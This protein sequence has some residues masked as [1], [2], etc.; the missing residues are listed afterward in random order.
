MPTLSELVTPF[1]E[2]YIATTR[3]GE[4]YRYWLNHWTRALGDLDAAALTADHIRT[5]RRDQLPRLKPSTINDITSALYRLFAYHGIPLPQRLRPLRAN[6]ARTRFLTPQDEE[7]LREQLSAGQWL[8]VALAIHSGLRRSE[9]FC[10][11]RNDIRDGFLHVRDSKNGSARFVPLNRVSRTVVTTLLAEEVPAPGTPWLFPSPY[12]PGRHINGDSF[13]QRVFKP[14]LR[15]AGIEDFRWHD[16]RHTFASR[17]VQR[18]APIDRIARLLGHSTLTTTLRYAHLA[19][20]DLS[21]AVALL[22]DPTET[23]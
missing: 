4:R 5:W 18:G 23:S 9:Q 11:T 21:A 15:R 10:L 2:E 16:L 14:A 19:P 7:R 6:N 1:I 17:L 3:S 22:D 12:Y 20:N 8:P 13:S